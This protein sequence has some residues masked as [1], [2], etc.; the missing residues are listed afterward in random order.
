MYN[1]CPLGKL[2]KRLGKYLDGLVNFSCLFINLDSP[3][4]GKPLSFRE[5]SKIAARNESFGTMMTAAVLDIR[6]WGKEDRGK[7]RQT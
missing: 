6:H 5:S 2:T 7:S 4:L 3:T 1:Q